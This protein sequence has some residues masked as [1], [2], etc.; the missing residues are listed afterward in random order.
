VTIWLS[1]RFEDVTDIG[2]ETVPDLSVRE[3]EDEATDWHIYVLGEDRVRA[4]ADLGIGAPAGELLH[5][6]WE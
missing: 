6:P 1:H 3:R 5:E 4:E 2:G